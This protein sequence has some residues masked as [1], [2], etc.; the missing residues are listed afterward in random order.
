MVR[1]NIII[2]MNSAQ[3]HSFPFPLMSHDTLISCRSV[4][5][6]FIHGLFYV[7]ILTNDNLVVLIILFLTRVNFRN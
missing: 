1:L 6:I 5:L 3:S 7:G 4:L 2:E